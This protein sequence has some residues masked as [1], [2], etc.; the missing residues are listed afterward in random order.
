MIKKL[1]SHL[2]HREQEPRNSY[3]QVQ[4]FY[5]QPANGT[6]NFG[7]LLSRVIIEK[8]LSQSHLTLEDEVKQEKRLLGVGSILHFARNGDHVWGSGV[9][10]KI[11]VEL[12]TARSLAIHAVRGPQTRAFL[13]E[14]GF[15]VPEIYGDPALLLP[16]LF[17]ER[18]VVDPQRDYIV[19]PNLHD[20]TLVQDDPHV[21]SPMIGW[22]RVVEEIVKAKM[23]VSS[24][25]HGLI[26][27]DAYNIPARYVRLSETENLFKYHDYYYGT[28]RSDFTYATSVDEALDMGSMPT[29]S[30]DPVPLMESFPYTL[31]S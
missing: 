19:I 11:P 5:W 30:Y 1:I 12:F 13:T 6:Q 23:V 18:F 8:L 16:T 26:I 21:V 4:V 22:N 27:A 29:L 17:P 9:N 31:W 14:R 24:S 25:L 2:R 28:G 20:L 15:S 3:P 10:G 7:D